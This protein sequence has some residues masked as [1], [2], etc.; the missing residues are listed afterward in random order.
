MDIKMFLEESS[1]QTIR[2]NWN[3]IICTILFPALNKNYKW[4]AVHPIK[5]MITTAIIAVF[6]V[7]ALKGWE[8]HN[9]PI[10]KN[11]IIHWKVTLVKEIP[12]SRTKNLNVQLTLVRVYKITFKIVLSKILNLEIMK[13]AF[14]LLI[15]FKV[16]I[17]HQL[18]QIDCKSI[19]GS[20]KLK[21]IVFLQ[22]N[23]LIHLRCFS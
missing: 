15:T 16:I 20:L 2:M 13:I 7:K 5:P 1:F 9:F 4:S 17:V 19:Q 8:E 6:L 14:N 3:Q 18:V 11:L 22:L 10:K 21:W 23:F 12:V